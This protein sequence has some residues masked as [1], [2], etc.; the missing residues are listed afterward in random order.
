MTTNS[1]A[2]T[3]GLARE[4]LSKTL[5]A[6][7]R[8]RVIAATYGPRGGSQLRREARDNSVQEIVEAIEGPTR[9][10]FERKEAALRRHPNT[11]H[12]SL[13]GRIVE[14]ADAEWQEVLGATSATCL[15]DRRLEI[16]CMV[17]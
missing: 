1:L 7:A 4:S 13:V 15:W 12:S 10:L 3:C 17:S 16:R 6:L 5:Q 2:E 14:E 11:K 9:S 8:A